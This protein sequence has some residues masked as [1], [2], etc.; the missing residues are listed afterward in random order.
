[1]SFI[2]R[3]FTP[4]GAGGAPAGSPANPI[5]TAATTVPAVSPLP[6]PPAAPAQPAPPASQ[7]AFAPSQSPAARQR[8]QVTA[9]S[10][11]GAA[12]T[13]SQTKKP[14]LG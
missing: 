4:P 13:A 10:L 3:A 8:A 2:T 14:T 12:A 1:M 9:T 11:L 5:P 7:A 6:P